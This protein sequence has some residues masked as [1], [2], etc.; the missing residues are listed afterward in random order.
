[1]GRCVD[2]ADDDDTDDDDDDGG[3]GV[4]VGGEA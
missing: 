3:I 2:D 4:E 1:M